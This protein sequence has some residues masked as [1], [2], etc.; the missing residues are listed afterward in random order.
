MRE[1]FAEA[2]DTTLRDVDDVE[3]SLVSCI[4]EAVRA[5]TQS[6]ERATLVRLVMAELPRFP[7][8]L[9]LWHGRGITP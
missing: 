9:D 1:R 4:R 6:P 5:V 8:L 3:K 7:A 2:V